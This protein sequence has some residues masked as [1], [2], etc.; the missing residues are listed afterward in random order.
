MQSKDIKKL[1]N[2]LE[3]LVYCYQFPS[4]T[5]HLQKLNRINLVVLVGEDHRHYAAMKSEN[6]K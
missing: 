1:K 6:C 4:D 5:S 2:E 3:S